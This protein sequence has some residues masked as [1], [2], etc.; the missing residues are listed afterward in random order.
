MEVERISEKE[1]QHDKKAAFLGIGK[2]KCLKKEKRERNS[3]YTPFYEM[4]EKEE[5]ETFPKIELS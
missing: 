3:S 4:Q 1:T 2:K 5:E